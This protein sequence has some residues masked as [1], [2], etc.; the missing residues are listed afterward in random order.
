[1]WS[2]LMDRLFYTRARLMIENRKKGPLDTE[3]LNE[4]PP[5]LNPD[6]N[7]FPPLNILLYQLPKSELQNS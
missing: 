3:D 7:P 4:L 2:R 5:W 6:T 1:M